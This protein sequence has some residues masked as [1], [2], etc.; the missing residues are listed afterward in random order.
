MLHFFQI[1][2]ENRLI[3]VSNRNHDASHF[4]IKVIEKCKKEDP[5]YRKIRENFWEL[6]L[7]TQINV[8][9]SHIHDAFK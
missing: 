8:I 6:T 3:K 7:K 1:F 4:S 9:K 5:F 2:C